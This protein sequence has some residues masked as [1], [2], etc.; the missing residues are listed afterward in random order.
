VRHRRHQQ[1]YW[2]PGAAPKAEEMPDN[3]A[4]ALNAQHERMQPEVDLCGQRYLG[5]GFPADISISVAL[6]ADGTVYVP[7]VVSSTAKD[8]GF[9]SCV[10]EVVAKQKFPAIDVKGPVPATIPFHYGRL[11]KL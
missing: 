4:G 3:A 9:D 5:E 11:E 8:G 2:A 6:V 10:L 7:T 1:G